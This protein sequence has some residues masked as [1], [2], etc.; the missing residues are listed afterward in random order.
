MKP[1]TLCSNSEC[2]AS[3]YKKLETNICPLC[4]QQT[5]IHLENK[6]TNGET[7]RSHSP[8]QKSK[9]EE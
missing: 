2:N 9:G 6:N 3:W 8:L 4:G 7:I 1:Q 5:L